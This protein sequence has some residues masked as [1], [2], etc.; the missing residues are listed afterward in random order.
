MYAL[1][2]QLNQGD[3]NIMT[4]EDPIEYELP[5]IN[6]VAVN[7]EHLG[8]QDALRGFLR[9][10]PDII[11]VGEVRD[12]ETAKIA[13]SAALTGHTVLSTMH[14]N[15]AAE[16]ITRLLDLGIEPF[17]IAS[18]TSLVM[19]QRLVRRVCPDCSEVDTPHERDL[20]RSGI[21]KEYLSRCT[22][23]RG[24]GCRRCNMMG[25]KGRVG[26][27]EVMAVTPAIRELILRGAS[28]TVIQ[29]KAIEEG[30]RILRHG[31]L[32]LAAKGVTTLREA[33]ENT[34]LA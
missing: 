4:V 5:G 20:A 24:R 17:N 33:I 7:G 19:A 23:R 12:A 9:Q 13:I 32:E 11:M 14:T 27:Y 18:A 22:F 2:T 21:P 3:V 29:Q 26:I 8:F 15:S 6:Q 10:D 25:F 16:A 28:T 34:V 30:M 1:L 31:A